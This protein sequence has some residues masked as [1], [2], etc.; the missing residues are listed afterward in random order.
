[1]NSYSI[2]GLSFRLSNSLLNGF[3]GNS[4]KARELVVMTFGLMAKRQILLLKGLNPFVECFDGLQFT[5]VAHLA[6]KL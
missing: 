3:I 6:E 4:T 1:M 2:S 5:I